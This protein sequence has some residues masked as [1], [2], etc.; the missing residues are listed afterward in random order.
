MPC[1]NINTIIQRGDNKAAYLDQLE[2]V[3]QVVLAEFQ[4]LRKILEGVRLDQL[5][6][7]QLIKQQRQ[8]KTIS[9]CNERLD[10]IRYTNNK[11]F[12][13]LIFIYVVIELSL[14]TNTKN[15]IFSLCFYLGTYVSNMKYMIRYSYEHVKLFIKTKWNSLYK[16]VFHNY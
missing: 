15:I 7:K 9:S 14:R 3:L 12:R 6:H 10:L 4:T 11:I 2:E 5:Y 1:C 13:E 8:I 16:N